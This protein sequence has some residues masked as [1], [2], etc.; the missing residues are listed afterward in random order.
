[1][2][3]CDLS[4]QDQETVYIEMNEFLMRFS[5]LESI[6]MQAM[7]I[8]EHLGDMIPSFRRETI[9]SIALE[10]NGIETDFCLY[11]HHMLNFEKLEYLNIS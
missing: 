8:G 2:H 10:Q 4:E 1:M 3:L 9:K 7:K 6:N 11:F 5:N